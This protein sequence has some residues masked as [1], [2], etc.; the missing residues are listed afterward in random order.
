MFENFR[1]NTVNEHILDAVEQQTSIFHVRFSMK[2]IQYNKGDKCIRNM[3]VDR[4]RCRV[5][6]ESRN[7]CQIASLEYT[8]AHTCN[9]SCLP[10]F[11]TFQLNF[12]VI[13]VV[14]HHFFPAL[15]RCA[16]YFNIFVKPPYQ[17]P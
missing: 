1:L 16:I 12:F 14:V 13:F 11:Q 10:F 17:I 4:V 6:I 3:R 5:A 2:I 15:F 9:K 8:F 7:P